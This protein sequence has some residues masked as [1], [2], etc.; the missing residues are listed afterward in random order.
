M[1]GTVV[2]AE[3]SFNRIGSSAKKKATVRGCFFS[4]FSVYIKVQKAVQQLLRLFIENL[5]TH[6][7]RIRTA[8]MTIQF[9]FY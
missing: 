5:I 7:N 9:S 4:V 3:A 6:S 1:S 8:Q 2:T